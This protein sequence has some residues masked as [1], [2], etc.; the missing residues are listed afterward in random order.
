LQTG[1]LLLQASDFSNAI[2][3]FTRVLSLTNSY[4]GRLNRALAYLQTGQC[5]AAEDDYQKML[6]LFPAAYQPYFGLAEVALRR[7]NTNAAIQ[8]YQQ[9]LSKAP[10]NQGEFQQVTARL[11]LLQPRAP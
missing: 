3:T 8:Q 6:R 9:Y 11:K 10:T 7:G 2:P 4:P 5:G 1:S